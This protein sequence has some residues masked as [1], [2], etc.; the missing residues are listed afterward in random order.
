LIYRE[1]GLFEMITYIAVHYFHHMSKLTIHDSFIRSIMA[2]KNIARDYFKNYLPSF[3]VNELDFETLE[4]SSDTYVSKELQKSMSDIVYN[5]ERKSRDGPA[6]ISLLIEHKSYPDKNAPIQIGSYIFSGFLKQIANKEEPVM[7]IPILLYHG[8]D[9]WNYHT[10]SDL[11]KNLVPEWKKFLP[12]FD[13]IYNDLGNIPDEQ[14]EAINNKF[15]SASLL[16]LK[17]SFEKNWLER[18]ILRLLVS[19]SVS[20][21]N[22]EDNLIVYLF[23][24]SG[25]E[26]GKIFNILR[27]L[28]S[29]SKDKIMNTLDIFV[30]KGK[31]I[32]LEY[33]K[34]IGLEDGKKIGMEMAKAEFVTNL[35]KSTDFDN[36]KIAAVAKVSEDFVAEVRQQV[37][38]N[39]TH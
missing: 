30:E 25:M 2:D 16:A 13:Y 26:E 1:T 9:K 7:I 5:C 37:F 21:S 34:K 15:L 36:G 4:Q 3:V 31:K 11:F 8:K 33:G 35:I 32:G 39:D 24:R 27:E 20:G 38:P 10:L 29:E 14:V 12:S 18:N 17:H 6:K 19:L 23:Q 22:L 28:P